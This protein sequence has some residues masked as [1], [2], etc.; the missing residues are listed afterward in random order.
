MKTL[1]IALLFL[2]TPVFAQLEYGKPEELKGLKKVFVETNGDM[3]N[4]DRIIKELDKAKLG[5]VILD[6]PDEAEILLVFSAGSETALST[7][8]S[9]VYGTKSN[10]TVVHQSKMQSGQGF[11]ALPRNGRARVLISFEDTEKTIWE[12]KPATNFAKTFIKAY[13]KAN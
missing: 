6:S 10:R 1:A 8:T 11:V 9:P 12:K 4:R 3:K 5:L 7:T 2:A 13:K